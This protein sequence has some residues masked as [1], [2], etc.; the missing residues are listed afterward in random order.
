VVGSL[1][2]PAFCG[3]IPFFA[4]PQYPYY[5]VPQ[6][7]TFVMSPVAAVQTTVLVFAAIG[8]AGFYVLLRRLFGLGVWAAVLGAALFMFNGFYAYRML[9]GH[10]TYHA[11]MLLPVAACFLLLPPPSDDTEAGRNSHVGPALG[12]GLV[13]AYM[14]QSGLVHGIP[15]VVAA[16]VALSVILALGT[17]WTARSWRGF[18]IRLAAAAI[19]ATSLSAAKLTAALAYLG[20]FPRDYYSLPGAGGLLDAVQVS[21]ASLFVGPAPDWYQTIVMNA[22]FRL[23]RHEFEYGITAVPLLLM[24]AGAVA[25]AAKWVGSGR[26]PAIAPRHAW[27]IASLSV[28]LALPVLFNWYTPAWNDVLKQV[29][30]VRNSVTLIR[31]IALYIPLAVLAGAIALDRAGLPRRLK[32]SIAIGGV[33]TMVFFNAA[34][35]RTYYADQPYQVA[36]VETAD[37][38]AVNGRSTPNIDHITT[39][40]DNQGRKLWRADRNDSLIS[41]GSQSLCYAPMFGY[42][43]EKFPVG[44]LRPGPVGDVRDGALN[45]KNPACFVYPAENACRPG[46]HF[47]VAR[48]ADAMAFASYRPFAFAAPLRQRVANGV[49]LAALVAVPA[50]LVLAMWRAARARRRNSGAP[51]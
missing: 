44:P 42:S 12:A 34:T 33:A 35:D 9:I 2:N 16:I 46:D 41:G 23:E 17:A 38:N 47:P 4:D 45:I 24:F 3:G 43:L 7:L 19:V 32:G 28:V 20:Q 26:P 50:L 6:F 21:F 22:S 30:M 5:S 15:I 36:A 10:L 29:P 13:F 14:F 8:Y 37:E 49:N 40:L 25:M 31:W 39:S 1:V 51:T 27:L 48:R 11:F 18:A